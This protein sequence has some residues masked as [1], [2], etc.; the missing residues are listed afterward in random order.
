MIIQEASWSCHSTNKASWL[1]ASIQQIKH[2]DWATYHSTNEVL[3]RVLQSQ[4]R[5]LWYTLP[6]QRSHLVS[7]L[8]SAIPIPLLKFSIFY[9]TSI[10]TSSNIPLH[11]NLLKHTPSSAERLQARWWGQTANSKWSWEK[12]CLLLV[13]WV[14]FHLPV[15]RCEV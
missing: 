14:N 9:Y 10:I 7:W 12:Y 4:N 11:T 2:H 13:T 15:A 3:I 6:P 1:R 8:F 5:D